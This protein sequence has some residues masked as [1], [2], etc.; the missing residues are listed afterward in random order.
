MGPQTFECTRFVLLH[1]PGVTDHV[2]SDNGGEFAFHSPATSAATPANR[3]YDRSA[4]LNSSLRHE[5][6]VTRDVF[7]GE[8]GCLK[9]WASQSEHR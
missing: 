3:C 1:E 4:L 8:S 9:N 6:E 2:G 7:W 5:C